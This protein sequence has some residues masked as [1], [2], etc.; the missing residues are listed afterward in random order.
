M[1]FLLFVTYLK[2]DE[3]DVFVVQQVLYNHLTPLLETGMKTEKYLN[4]FQVGGS[5]N[6]LPHSTIRE[7]FYV[8]NTFL[9]KI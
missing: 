7:H 9:A 2:P 4:P 8:N 6:G 5:H 1:P 3:K